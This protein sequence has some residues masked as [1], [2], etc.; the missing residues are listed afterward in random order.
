MYWFVTL[1]DVLLATFLTPCPSRKCLL[2]LFTPNSVVLSC[3]SVLRAMYNS[4]NLFFSLR[5]PDDAVAPAEELGKMR[6]RLALK[7]LHHFNIV[8]E[9]VET[10]S[11]YNPL[12]PNQPCVSNEQNMTCHACMLVSYPE[13]T[14]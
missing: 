4:H 12:R 14:Q 2:S 6:E 8:P 10:R 13:D 7:V 11:L 5:L 9:H 3:V 1:S